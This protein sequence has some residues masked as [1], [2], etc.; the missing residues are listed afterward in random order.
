MTTSFIH[1]KHGNTHRQP[2]HALS[3]DDV[4]KAVSFIEGFVEDH[5]ILLPGRIPGYNRSD[6]KLLPSS[7]TKLAVWERYRDLVSD[8][9]RV[10]GYRS[11]RNIWRKYLPQVIIT[12]PMTDL[13]LTCQ[14]NNSLILRSVNKTEEEKSTVRYVNGNYFSYMYNLY[15]IV[16]LDT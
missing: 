10:V 1:R 15:L 8:G 6:L 7:I 11:F 9:A 3:V 14:K 12:K 4:K 2:V 13:C 5:G 16:D